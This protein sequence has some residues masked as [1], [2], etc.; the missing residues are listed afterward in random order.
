MKATVILG[1]PKKDPNA[2]TQSYH[3][4]S[5]ERARRATRKQLKRSKDAVEKAQKQLRGH[6][7]RV[8]QIENNAKKNYRN[9]SHSTL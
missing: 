1:R 4:S 8:K 7:N 3:L 9:F 5:L 2:P 6:K